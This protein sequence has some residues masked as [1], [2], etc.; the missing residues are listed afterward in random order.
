MS[1]SDGNIS[2]VSEDIEFIPYTLPSVEN[3]TMYDLRQVLD[4]IQQ[5]NQDFLE[6]NSKLCMLNSDLKS[7]LALAKW[8]KTSRKAAD[9]DPLLNH[10]Q[11]VKLGKK[12]VVTVFP[13]PSTDL[14]MCRPYQI[15]LNLSHRSVLRMAKQ[16]HAA[17]LHTV[18]ECAYL[19]MTG[20]DV[21]PDVWILKAGST[22]RHDSMVVKALLEFPGS[23]AVNSPCSPIFYPNGEQDNTKLFMN[24]YQPKSLSSDSSTFNYG[25]S[26][27]GMLWGVKS[28]N[29]AC[30]VFS[31]I[32]VSKISKINYKKDFITYCTFLNGLNGTNYL[33]M[34][35]IFYNQ[36]VFVGMPSAAAATPTSQFDAVTEALLAVRL[37]DNELSPGLLATS[38]PVI[39]LNM[40]LR[41]PEPLP[42]PEP[43][44]MDADPAHL[45]DPLAIREANNLDI[46][47]GEV[48]LV[49][50]GLVE[51][52]VGVGPKFQPAITKEKPWGVAEL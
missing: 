29:N 15:V 16:G 12:Y 2:D 22:L 20:M 48:G 26:L 18:R 21:Q 40:G 50:V 37:A 11:I 3:I 28:V 8:Q 23:S 27:V 17:M 6:H 34:L 5:Q 10:E 4:K 30:I 41:L 45:L 43:N 39:V 24:E 14:F 46:V 19:I 33:K 51:A 32:I 9:S 47:K 31:G 44:N 49:V 25:S 7:Q 36:S 35:Y 42:A 13:W 52:K 38:T 1:D